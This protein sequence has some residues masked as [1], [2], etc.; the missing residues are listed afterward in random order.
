[1]MRSHLR[2]NAA[3]GQFARVRP[4]L[5]TAGAIAERLRRFILTPG[6]ERQVR[7]HIQRDPSLLAYHCNLCNRLNACSASTL[8]RETPSCWYCDST[9]RVRAVVDILSNKLLGDSLPLNAFPRRKDLVG[10]GLSDGHHYATGLKRAFRYRNT[11]LHRRPRLDL[12]H[13]PA[14]VE[15]TLD[16]LVAS[17]VLEHVQPPIGVALASARG[18]MKPGGLMIITTPY[19]A[20]PGARTLEH[21]PRLHDF[22]VVSARGALTLVNRTREGQV[23]TF[24]NPPLHGGEG[25]VLE[26][27]LFSLD[28][29]R[30]ELMSAGFQCV[31]V[32]DHETPR[33]GIL[34][35]EPHS[36]P[37]LAFA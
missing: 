9:V 22:Q 4:H 7:D 29:L 35:Q 21:F 28:D 26:M 17:E 20:T 5:D 23:E 33:F 10:L 36:R 37:L 14:G 24:E 19:D 6:H 1:M 32:W 18:L 2:G 15:G 31:E 25:L 13:P 34:W 12:L 27:R 11:F 16:F 3:V 30:S 8:H